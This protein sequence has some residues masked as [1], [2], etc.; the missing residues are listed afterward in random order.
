MAKKVEQVVRLA[1]GGAQMQVGNPDRSESKLTVTLIIRRMRGSA[2][3]HAV[4]PRNGRVSDR[5]VGDD[6]E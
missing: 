6:P 1:A 4:R 2:R 5:D 3:A